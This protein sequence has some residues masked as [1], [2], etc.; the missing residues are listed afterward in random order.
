M[1]DAA[2][3]V[4]L[5]NGKG[6]GYCYMIGRGPNLCLLGHVT[7]FLYC[8]S[9]KLFFPQFQFSRLLVMSLIV[10]DIELPETKVVKEL[11]VYFDGQVFGFSSKRPKNYQST[12]QT[13]WCTQNLHK[14]DWKSGSLDCNRINTMLTRLQQ[15]RAEYFAKRFEKC[16]FVSKLLGKEVETLDHYGCTKILHLNTDWLCT[17]YSYRHKTNLHSTERKAKAFGEWTVQHFDL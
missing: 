4:Y 8:L 3:A 12:H 2:G 11:G 7:E 14:I 17:S 10:L 5:H 1:H 6:P 15:Y 9:L 13:L 16:T